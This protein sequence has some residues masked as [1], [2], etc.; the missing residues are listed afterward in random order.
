MKPTSILALSRAMIAA[1]GRNIDIAITGLR[2]GEKLRGELFDASESVCESGL[3][4]VYEVAPAS[5]DAYLTSGDV[6]VLEEIARGM[7]DEIVRR[8]VFAF[9]DACL[10]RAARRAG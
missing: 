1:S 4:G 2:P 7:D 10:G 3:A 8:R 9:V 5:P 6:G